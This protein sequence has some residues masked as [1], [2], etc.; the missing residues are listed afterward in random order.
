ME[1]HAEKLNREGLK[2]PKKN[3]RPIQFDY[4]MGRHSRNNADLILH[5]IKFSFGLV[6]RLGGK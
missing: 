6:I 4:L 1:L 5:S 3:Y 2:D